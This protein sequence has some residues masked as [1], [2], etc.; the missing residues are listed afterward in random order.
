MA[1][2][3][4]I[5]ASTNPR[6]GPT[7]RWALWRF[8]TRRLGWS[9]LAGVALVLLAVAVHFTAVRAAQQELAVARARIEALRQ[10]P[11]ARQGVP[12][13]AVQ[14]QFDALHG[15]F[16]GPEARAAALVRITALAE[17]EGL[18]PESGDYQEILSDTGQKNG[19][20]GLLRYQI[21]LPLHGPYPALR[22]WL[23]AVMNEMPALA[24]DDFSLKR[25]SVTNPLVEARVRLT[26]YFEER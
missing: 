26:L 24:L 4:A 21:T 2:P 10:S 17:K 3:T 11:A 7:L 13:P 22:A 15:F 8:R 19:A 14:R 18:N 20:G 23:V 9:G 25:D 5:T 12:Q 16:P 1:A 6:P